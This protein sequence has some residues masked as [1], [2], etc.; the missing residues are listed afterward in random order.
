M[1]LLKKLAAGNHAKCFEL[2]LKYRKHFIS[3]C[4][5]LKMKKI[6]PLKQIFLMRERL[7]KKQGTEDPLGWYGYAGIRR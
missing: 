7:V 1:D 4:C 3:S 2:L 6:S 5:K